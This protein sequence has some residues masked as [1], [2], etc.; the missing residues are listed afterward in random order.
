[1]CMT[2]LTMYMLVPGEIRK[3]HFDPLNLSLF[4]GGGG[5]FLAVV[6]FYWVLCFVFVIFF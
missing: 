2:V 3:E 4:A 1:M 6:L 5:G